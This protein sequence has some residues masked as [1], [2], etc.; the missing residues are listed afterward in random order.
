LFAL[1]G[2]GQFDIRHSTFV[3][4]VCPRMEDQEIYAQRLASLQFIDHRIAAS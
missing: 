4:Q 1:S 2:V 3:A